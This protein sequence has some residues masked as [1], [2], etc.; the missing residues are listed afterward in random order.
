MRLLYSNKVSTSLHKLP[1]LLP[2]LVSGGG[3]G[4]T[5]GEKVSVR[6]AP[7]EH[8]GDLAGRHRSTSRPQCP[9]FTGE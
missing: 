6:P 1:A 8:G 7:H 9:Q 5:A 4:V 3:G 2:S